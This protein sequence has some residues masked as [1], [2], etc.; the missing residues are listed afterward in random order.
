MRNWLVTWDR[1]TQR[2]WI[3]GQRCHH[4]PVGLMVVIVGVLVAW[5]DWKDRSVWFARERLAS[6]VLDTS[7]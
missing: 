1:T 6:K 4:G 5:H 3:C 7:S 2:V